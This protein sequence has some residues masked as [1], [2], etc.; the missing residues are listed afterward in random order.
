MRRYNFELAKKELLMVQRY[1]ELEEHEKWTKLRNLEYSNQTSKWVSGLRKIHWMIMHFLW[2]ITLPIYGPSNISRIMSN[3]IY[4][5]HDFDYLGRYMKLM[6][7]MFIMLKIIVY[8]NPTLNMPRI[9]WQGAIHYQFGFYR[10]CVFSYT[11]NANVLFLTPLT[12]LDV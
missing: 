8:H 4:F 10:L 6:I 11:N 9:S 5:N 1:M 7:M 12:H 2:A 3:C